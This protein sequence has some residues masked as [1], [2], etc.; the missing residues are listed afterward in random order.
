MRINKIEE[1]I[2][3]FLILFLIL[4]LLFCIKFLKEKF[5]TLHCIANFKWKKMIPSITE[6][7]TLMATICQYWDG[8]LINCCR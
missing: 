3:L 1:L 7:Q 6:K 8:Q 5:V 4:L 2:K